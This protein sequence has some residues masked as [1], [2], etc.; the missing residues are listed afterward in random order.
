MGL[1]RLALTTVFRLTEACPTMKRELLLNVA[2]CCQ[3]LARL[4]F[5]WM[6]TEDI[7]SVLAHCPPLE[8]QLAWFQSKPTCHIKT[9]Y[10]LW[11]K[12]VAKDG[13][14]SRKYGCYSAGGKVWISHLLPFCVAELSISIYFVKLNRDNFTLF[15]FR[16]ACLYNTF[17]KS[18]LLC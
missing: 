8:K 3:G 9:K 15:G 14:Y 2:V 4:W 1:H 17:L 12:S 11:R 16:Q 6:L 18:L 10:S 5:Q 7:F 13:E